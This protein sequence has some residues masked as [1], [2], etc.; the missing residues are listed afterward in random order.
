MHLLEQQLKTY[1]ILI[2]N[3][4]FQTIIITTIVILLHFSNP[5]YFNHTNV[6]DILTFKT[7]N[8]NS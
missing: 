6:Q 1:Y 7:F 5:H 8:L 4:R 3:P 2:N